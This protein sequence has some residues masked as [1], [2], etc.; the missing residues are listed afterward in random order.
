[1]KAQKTDLPAV[2]WAQN[3]DEIDHEIARL[4]TLCRVKVLEAGVIERVLHKDESVCGSS[5][6]IAFKKLHD[7]LMLHFAIRQKSA[8]VVG[9]SDTPGDADCRRHGAR[10]DPAHA[11]RLLGPDG[12]R[13]HGRSHGRHGAHDL[14]RAG[15]LRRLVQSQTR[16]GCCQGFHRRSAA[17]RACA[18]ITPQ[19]K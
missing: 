14:L 11:Q 2:W 7:M 18:L 9:A 15:P 12:P 8:D 1:M 10:H 19:I 17:A 13:H 3:L 5:N 4:A 16:T 6:A